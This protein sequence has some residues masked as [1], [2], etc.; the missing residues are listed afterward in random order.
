M[1]WSN[2]NFDPFHY[3]CVLSEVHLVHEYSRSGHGRG[4]IVLQI[5]DEA[6]GTVA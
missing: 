5:A 1:S 2:Q 6:E 3:G 4:R